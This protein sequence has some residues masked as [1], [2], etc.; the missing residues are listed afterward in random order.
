MAIEADYVYIGS[1]GL[2][3]AVVPNLTYDPATGANYP[4]NDLSRRVW[5][6]WGFVKWVVNGGRADMHSLQT[7]FTKRMSGGW[8]ASGTYT[9]SVL[10]DASALPRSGLELVPFRTVPDIGGE[11]SLAVGDQRHRAVFNGIWQL[12]YGFQLSGLYFFGSGER[13]PTSWG[14]DLRQM[15]T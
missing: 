9:L 11:Y 12:R 15:G 6:E 10:K 8:Q 7:A 3:S 1:R 5:P 2:M 14:T 13:F 4:F